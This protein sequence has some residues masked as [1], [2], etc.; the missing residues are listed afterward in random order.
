MG[1]IHSTEAGRRS[2]VTSHETWPVEH[3][4]A[5]EL[6]REAFIQAMRDEGISPR[7]RFTI[8]ARAEL[9]IH[10]AL[11]YDAEERDHS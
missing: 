9:K 2:A 7:T 3:D 11:E 4:R 5:I 1:P 8:S 6:V 10:E